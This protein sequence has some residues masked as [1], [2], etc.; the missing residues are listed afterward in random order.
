MGMSRPCLCTHRTGPGSAPLGIAQSLKP[1]I[2]SNHSRRTG[3]EQSLT[4]PQAQVLVLPEDG[5]QQGERIYMSMTVSQE[6]WSQPERFLF[7]FTPCQFVFSY[8]SRFNPTCGSIAK[9]SEAWLLRIRLSSSRKARL[10][11]QWSTFSIV[12]WP[13]TLSAIRLASRPRRRM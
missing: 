13:Q 10:S 11:S 6:S 12:Q 8:L 5:G 7:T 9:F 3:V 2:Y 4:L 1:G